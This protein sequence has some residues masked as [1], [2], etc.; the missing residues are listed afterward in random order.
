MVRSALAM[1]EV[2]ALPKLGF[3]KVVRASGGPRPQYSD[4]RVGLS[5]HSLI[6]LRDVGLC[7]A[8]FRTH[9]DCEFQLCLI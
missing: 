8:Q 7:E 4:L 9:F 6:D 5:A 2:R 1:G 3:G